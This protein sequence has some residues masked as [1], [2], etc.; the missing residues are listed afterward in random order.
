MKLIKLTLRI[1]L[2]NNIKKMNT[3]S[4]EDCI[5]CEGKKYMMKIKKATKKMKL[6]KSLDLN[7]LRTGI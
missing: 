4:N 7:G 3:L 6:N 5:L 1:I 2:E